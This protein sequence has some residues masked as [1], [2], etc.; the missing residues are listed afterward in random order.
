MA[1]VCWLFYISK[2]VELLDT[3][4]FIMRKKF[5]QV[6]FLHVFHHGIMPCTWWF[7]IRFVPGG[8]GSFHALINSFIHFVMYAYYGLAALGP[9]YQKYLW[10]K[11]YMTKMQM[12]QFILVMIHSAQLFF[13][14]CDYP[15]FFSIWICSYAIIFMIFFTNFYIQEYIYRRNK[16]ECLANK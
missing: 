15:K 9:E 10:W 16:D 2:F 4:F 3:V 5:N 11:K 12:I 8:F 6:T 7:G 14:E 13:I 1:N